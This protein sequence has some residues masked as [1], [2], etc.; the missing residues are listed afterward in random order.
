MSDDRSN[1]ADRDAEGAE[2][3][4]VLVEALRKIGQE[5]QSPHKWL[6]EF[7]G[8]IKETIKR[9]L[10]PRNGESVKEQERLIDDNFDAALEEVVS[11][12]VLRS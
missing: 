7:R 4:A 1:E 3:R 10:S 12:F 9:A 2:V 8:A 11:E 5:A 6:V